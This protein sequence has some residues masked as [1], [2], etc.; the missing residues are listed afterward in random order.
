[1]ALIEALRRFVKV[2]ME[3]GFN[4]FLDVIRD[5]FD[6]SLIYPMG[7]PPRPGWTLGEEFA[8]REGQRAAVLQILSLREK[9]LTEAEELVH[10]ESEVPGLEEERPQFM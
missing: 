6:E 1:M 7:I 5:R 9:L 4:V 3:P 2:A 10:R 8:Y